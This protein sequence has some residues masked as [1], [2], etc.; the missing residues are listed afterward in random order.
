LQDH[1]LPEVEGEGVLQ[2]M[3]VLHLLCEESK[4]GHRPYQSAPI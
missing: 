1:R 4:E 2:E 3:V